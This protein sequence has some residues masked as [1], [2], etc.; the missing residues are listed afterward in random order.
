[1]NRLA[2]ACICLTAL[3]WT[4]YREPPASVKGEVA[5]TNETPPIVVSDADWPWWR[6]PDLD[7]KS[8]DRAAPTTW[9]RTENVAWKTDVPGRGHASPIVVGS[10]IFLTTADEQGQ[11]QLILAFDRKTGKELWSTVAHE[12]GFMAKHGKNSHASATPA[13]DGE[14]VYSVFINRTGLHV[15]A[16]DLD[17]KIA[18]QTEAGSF[19]SEHGYGSSPVLYKSLVIVLGDNRTSCFVAAL[20]RQTGKVVWRT[21][22]KTTG[23][24]GSYA[25]PIVARV[26]G[27]QQ[28]LISGMES[29]TSYDPGTGKQVWTCFGPAEVTAC[30]PAFSDQLVFSSGGYPEKELLAIRANGTGDITRSHVA[31]RTGKGVTYVP[32]PIY[33]AG[34]LYVVSDDGVTTCFDGKTGKENWKGRLQGNF[35]SSPV[36]AG[37][38]LYVTNEAGKTYVFK[39]GPKF[40]IVAQNDLGN[41]GFATPAICGGQIF[42]RTE[43]ALYC[44]GKPAAQSESSE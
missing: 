28:L 14:R 35:S 1:M 44:V 37:N 33:H 15:T 26:A 36:L 7:G 27:K 38:L 25:T 9:S 32:S 20:D 11:K 10:Q 18:W 39:A 5:L 17:G 21:D 4:G 13:C 24:H 41:S 43:H 12:G 30:T 3:A 8:R 22:R 2:L 16:T 23:K 40:E 34:L 29:T 6:G 31:W 42:L 19:G